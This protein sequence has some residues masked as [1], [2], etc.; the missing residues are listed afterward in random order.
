MLEFIIAVLLAVA[1]FCLGVVLSRGDKNFG[2]KQGIV[3]LIISISLI[4]ISG[5]LI[6]WK[7]GTLLIIKKIGAILLIVFGWFMTFKFPQ[8]DSWQ[9]KQFALLGILVGLFFLFLGLYWLLF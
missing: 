9:P 2:A 7:F 6:I 1:F 8:P 5:F 3:L 4:V